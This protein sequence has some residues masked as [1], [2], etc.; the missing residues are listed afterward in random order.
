MRKWLGIAG[1]YLLAYRLPRT[2]LPLVGPPSK[3]LRATFA[4]MFLRHVG[5]NVNIDAECYLGKGRISIG[6]NSGLGRLCEVHG[7]LTIGDNVLIAPEVLFYT[8]N[9]EFSSVDR[10]IITQGYGQEKAIV[11]EDDVWLGRRAVIMPGV[12]IGTGA[13]VAACSVVTKDIIAYDIVGGVP[14][15]V[16]GTRN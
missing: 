11:I 13:V 15:K 1:Y 8:R 14:A 10:P 4:R 9:H 7:D 16:I 3:T 5:S 2:S 12:R 6:N